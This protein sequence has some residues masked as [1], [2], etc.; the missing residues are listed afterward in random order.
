M[1]GKSIPP[2]SAVLS[3]HARLRWTLLDK[4]ETLAESLQ[5]RSSVDPKQNEA[6]LTAVS[7][8]RG[9]LDPGFGCRILERGRMLHCCS[10]TWKPHGQQLYYGFA[11]PNPSMQITI[12]LLA[13][14]QAW[15][16][17]QKWKFSKLPD[18]W[19][20]KASNELPSLI[21][22]HCSSMLFPHRW[23]F[24]RKSPISIKETKNM[25][26]STKAPPFSSLHY[27]TWKLGNQFIHKYRGGWLFP[28][29]PL[30]CKAAAEKIF[31]QGLYDCG[32]LCHVEVCEVL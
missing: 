11:K 7:A 13:C 26:G 8:Q 23:G 22:L 2:R 16:G 25:I 10:L 19:Q 4:I 17:K 6:R 12:I 15:T 5:W 18:L 29:L 1:T 24:P 3:I 30:L 20:Y 9:R 27:L 21:S 32:C 14:R 31:C 28:G